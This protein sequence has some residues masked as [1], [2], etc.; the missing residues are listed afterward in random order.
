[1]VGWPVRSAD[2]IQ[3]LVMHASFATR[4]HAVSVSS[5]VAHEVADAAVWAL[6]EEAQLTP[7]PGLVDRRGSGVHRDMD[8]PMLLRSAGALHSTFVRI[9][10]CA[11]RVPFGMSLRERLGVI[12]GAGEMH[13][14]AA[15]GG[16]NTH[17]GAIW[18]LGL[19]AA[20]SVMVESGKF[21][22]QD[23]CTLAGRIARLPAAPSAQVSHG[24]R[25]FLSYGARGA[26]GEAEN[27][28]PHIHQLA[29]PALQSARARFRTE[30]L[31][32]LHVLVS[33]IASVEDTCLLFRGGRAA[34]AVAQEGAADVLCAGIDTPRGQAR[35]AA[36]DRQ[37]L[38]LNA[39]PGGCADLLAAT[40]FLDRLVSTCEG[41]HGNA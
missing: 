17:R 20:A 18:A 40:L 9:A 27:G 32:R 34:L 16:V 38:A 5:L 2:E 11:V 30:S 21:D 15:T 6:R 31:A 28:F 1:M 26:R 39:S 35:L 14:F 41:N 29:L 12:G 10:D 23:I 33:L 25:M 36:L 13:M 22:A 7:K 4:I 19:L 37:L 8:L 3:E 24:R